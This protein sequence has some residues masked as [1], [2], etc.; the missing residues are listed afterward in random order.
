[1]RQARVRGQAMVEASVVI[2]L[3]LGIALGLITFGHAFMVANMITH[4]ARDGARV[5]AT[6]TPRGPCGRL[7]NTNAAAIQTM[8][9]NEIRAVT[10]ETFSV[11]ISQNW[12]P[13]G[14]APC[15]TPTTPTVQVNVQ[16]CVP[17]VFPLLLPRSI[18]Y[19]CGGKTGFR[20]DRT[21]VFHDETV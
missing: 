8:V 17:Y 18:G 10:P 13:P 14:S 7:D 20:V 5:A 2:V 4:A 19:D 1:M 11:N 16:G 9:Q 15:G 21:V 3:F 12:T 6:W